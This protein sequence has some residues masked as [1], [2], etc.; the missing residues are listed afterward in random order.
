M[1]EHNPILES[2]LSLPLIHQGKVR[3]VYEVDE[4]TLLMVAS[5]RVSAFDVVLPQP[6]PNKGAVLTQITAWW[7]KQLES[8]LDHHL[9]AVDPDEI[10]SSIE[11]FFPSTWLR[12]QVDLLLHSGLDYLAGNQEK[13]LIDSDI[14]HRLTLFLQDLA[15]L[16]LS[17]HGYATLIDEFVLSEVNEIMKY[18]RQLPF[19]IHLTNSDIRSIVKSNNYWQA[20]F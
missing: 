20:K 12:T 10:A 1:F 15:V 16:F 5:D 19:G 2:Q 4:R 13:L 8:H 14:S 18:D 11:I 3:D 9:I 6:I 7:L 17:E